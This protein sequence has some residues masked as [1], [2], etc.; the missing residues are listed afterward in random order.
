[1]PVE[2]AQHRS[3]AWCDAPLP[4]D[5]HEQRRFCD[6]I[7][8]SRSNQAAH[9]KR[10]R[11]RKAGL[12]PT[13]KAEPTR[14]KRPSTPAEP[15]MPKVPPKAYPVGEK[16]AREVFGISRWALQRIIAAGEIGTVTLNGTRFIS[17]E[18]VDRVLRSK[19]RRER[20]A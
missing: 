5:A 10:V 4:A 14:P 12:T 18:E 8:K 13:L 1:M 17:A 7:C 20:S 2:K 9:R 19:L 11:E 16:T 15:P 6:H 3:C